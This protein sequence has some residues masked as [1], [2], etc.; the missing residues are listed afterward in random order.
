L[1]SQYIIR[2]VDDLQRKLPA[3]TSTDVGYSADRLH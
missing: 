1:A 3:E 2:P